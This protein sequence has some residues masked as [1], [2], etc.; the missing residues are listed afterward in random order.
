MKPIDLGVFLPIGSHGFILSKNSLPY[1]GSFQENMAITALAEEIGLDFVFSMAKWRGFGGDIQFWDSSLESFSLMALLASVT[2]RINLVATV[3]PLLF[4]PVMLSKMV[5]TI[6]DATGGR[7]AL[8][9]ITGSTIGEYTQMGIVPE[10]YDENRY[11][12]LSEWLEALKLLWTE[13]RVNFTGKHFQLQ[14]CV[15]DPKP[16]KLPK[17]YCAASS[18]EGMR[19][20]ARETDCCFINGSDAKAVIGNAQ[21]ARSAALDQGRHIQIA[22]P[23]VIVIGDTRAE[24]DAEW[25][26]YEA[27]ADLVAIE[28]MT[29]ALGGQ[30]R[31]SAQANAARR[32]AGPPRIHAGVP[33]IGTAAEIADQLSELALEGGIDSM[34][35]I[36]SDYMSGLRRVGADVLPRLRQ[37]LSL[38]MAG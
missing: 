12:F 37:S 6:D 8:N 25:A 3:N 15:S 34:L 16:A 10:G 32:R 35:F 5:A 9:L 24:A 29:N 13:P 20:V 28:N 2:K 36:F 18:D 4:H 31:A 22:A 7:L 30:K 33:I 38:S 14:D 23:V 11:A 1:S 26:R 19:F 17:L 27:G 21:R